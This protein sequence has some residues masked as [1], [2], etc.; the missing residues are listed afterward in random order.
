MSVINEKKTFENK[1]SNKHPTGKAV[2][3]TEMCYCLLNEKEVFTD[4]IFVNISTLPLEHH[5]KF[6]TSN[7]EKKFNSAR[8]QCI[9]E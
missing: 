9:H 4:M 5:C 3:T 6:S 1:R 8:R 7:N 2:A